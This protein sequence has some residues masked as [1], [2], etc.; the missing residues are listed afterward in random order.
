MSHLFGVGLNIEVNRIICD[1]RMH[2]QK[3]QGIPLRS[4]SLALYKCGTEITS[5][6]FERV[7]AQFA[8]FTT[9]VQM[10]ALMKAFNSNGCLSVADFLTALRP[11]L[12]GRRAAIVRAAW[13]QISEG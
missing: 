10:Q 7:L 9:K 11:R 3:K 12:D 4:L 6:Q 1:F 2:I 8:I 13:N 5:L